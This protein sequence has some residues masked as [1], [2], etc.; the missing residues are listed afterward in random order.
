MGNG[1]IEEVLSFGR[2]P[3]SCVDQYLLADVARQLN[4]GVLGRQ[5]RCRLKRK[6]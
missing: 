5:A 3:F 6:M 1:F 4:Y 2:S